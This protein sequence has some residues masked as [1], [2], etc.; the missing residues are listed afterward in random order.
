[1]VFHLEV[2]MLFPALLLS[3]LP[4]GPAAVLDLTADFAPLFIGL[5]TVLGPSLLGLV[6]TIATHDPREENRQ[7][8]KTPAHLVPVPDLPDAA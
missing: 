4:A 8:T 3:G 1:V 7:D 5:W 6:V 2:K